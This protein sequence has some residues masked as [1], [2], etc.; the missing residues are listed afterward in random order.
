M[1]NLNN[2]SPIY[3][4]KEKNFMLQ[5][6]RFSNAKRGSYVNSFLGRS[7]F[8]LLA[9]PIDAWA[10]DAGLRQ[11]SGSFIPVD[12]SVSDESLCIKADLP[13]ISPDHISVEVD[14]DVL[15][16]EVTCENGKDENLENHVLKERRIGST[17]R[18]ITLPYPIQYEGVRSTY[19]D[20]LL[21]INLPRVEKPKGK[22]IPIN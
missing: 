10:S 8:P 7:L 17:V 21:I 20:G 18:K 12:L 11:D 6:R 3:G 15:T 4:N 14:E 2:G 1:I 16:I 5:K 9:S 13:G 19:K 22:K